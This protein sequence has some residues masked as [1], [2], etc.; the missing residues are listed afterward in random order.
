VLW[1]ILPDGMKPGGA[2]MNAAYH[3]RRNGIR[4][5]LITR[6]GTD[7]L[8][9]ELLTTLHSWGLPTA[10]CQRDQRLPT[11]TVVAKM[12]ADHEM[13]YEIVAPV[14]WDFIGWEDGYGT[15]AASADAVVFGSLVM[16]NAVSR[17]TLDK[18]LDA[19]RYRVF[20]VNLRAPHYTREDIFSALGKTDLLKLNQ[21]ELGVI[22]GWTGKEPSADEPGNVSRLLELFPVTGVIV[23]R[24]K[25]GAT[26]YEGDRSYHH[27]AYRVT[28][29]DTVG[30]G[31]AFLA[32]F[33]AARFRG[34]DIA[35][36]LEA[37]SVLGA[38]VAARKGACPEYHLREG[39][40]FLRPED[41]TRLLTR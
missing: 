7:A 37:A 40:P 27:P 26:Y 15:A 28:V 6:V 4:S 20:D 9:D 3:L 17:R 12:D 35:G 32:A 18:L 2:P 39:E 11:G 38:F 25:D 22:T 21:H 24:G 31:D 19:A 23:T 10:L 36:S 33:L 8:G 41:L 14:A 5:D 13:N 1:D 30:A 16:R 29:A 34:Q